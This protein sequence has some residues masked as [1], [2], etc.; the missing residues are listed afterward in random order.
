MYININRFSF[1]FYTHQNDNIFNYIH[2][3]NSLVSIFT[4][5]E[6]CTATYLI[7]WKQTKDTYT[8][9]RFSGLFI[10]TFR[11]LSWIWEVFASLILNYRPPKNINL[12]LSCR[13]VNLTCGFK[14]FNLISIVLC[15]EEAHKQIYFPASCYI[16][17]L[18]KNEACFLFS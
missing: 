13:P 7:W 6:K 2:F 5:H 10:L 14:Y 17:A 8:R 1:L 18:I 9:I 3:K 15:N 4:K 11:S 16:L 12:K